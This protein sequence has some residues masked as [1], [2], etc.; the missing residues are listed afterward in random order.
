M[1]FAAF[2]RHAILASIAGVVLATGVV[3][4]WHVRDASAQSFAAAP[5]SLQAELNRVN[6]AGGGIV[7]LPA[8]QSLRLNG[9]LVVPRGVVLDLGGNALQITLRE[10]GDAGVRLLSGATIRN[11]SINVLS[12][13]QRGIQAGAHAAI[14]VG[15]LYGANLSVDRVSP[16]ESPTGWAIS[17]VTVTSDKAGLQEGFHLGAAGIQIVGGASDGLIENVTVPDSAALAGAIMLDWGFVGPL[18]SSAVSASSAAFARSRAYTT[19]PHDIVIRNV[20]IGRLSRPSRNADGSFGIRLSGV[21][22]VTVS[23]VEIASVTE[24][25]I[26]HT[27]GDFGYEFAR[28]ADQR[29]AHQG[30]IIENVRVEHADGGSILRSDSFADNIAR[31]AVAG[32]R[33]RRAPIATTDMIVRNVTGV[34]GRGKPPGYGFRVNHQRGGKFSDVSA[35]GFRRG[36]YIDEQVFDFILERPT[37]IDS[38]EAG[39]SVEHPYRPPEGI[40]IIQPRATGTNAASRRLKIGRSDRVEVSNANGEVQVDVAAKGFVLSR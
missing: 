12:R 15:A 21:H 25:G 22:D 13:G 19:H 28:A 20:K 17:N 36:F 29:R 5:N 18:D 16:F 33:P 11:G 26:L 27:A 6:A 39:L 40:R 1:K 32:Y 31:A 24:A 3:T 14:M 37:A 30:I 34:A 10:A 8:R 38:I 35:R 23:G 4:A 7:T 9:G 2:S